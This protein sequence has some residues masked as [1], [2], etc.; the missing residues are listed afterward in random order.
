MHLHYPGIVD[1]VVVVVV[2]MYSTKSSIA[3][4]ERLAN[5]PEAAAMS[6]F[7]Q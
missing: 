1:V 7:E 6:V 3:Q 2:Y 4:N 5:S